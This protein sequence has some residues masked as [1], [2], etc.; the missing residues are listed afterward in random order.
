MKRHLVNPP[1]KTQEDF[2]CHFVGWSL[3]T[4]LG[5]INTIEI[6]LLSPQHKQKHHKASLDQHI[7]NK[8][9]FKL[10]PVFEW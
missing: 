3:P 8:T 10:Y 7:C 9:N 6:Y 4:G 1:V 5:C 2:F